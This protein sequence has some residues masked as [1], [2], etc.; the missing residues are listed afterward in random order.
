M[1]TS[2]AS[3]LSEA[4]YMTNETL[5]LCW[6]AATIKVGTASQLT[7]I[8]EEYLLDAYGHVIAHMIN[9][10]MIRAVPQGNSE[11]TVNAA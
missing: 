3:M 4:R 9:G 11:V 7:G 10:N 1:G 2:I 6:N 8:G 5:E